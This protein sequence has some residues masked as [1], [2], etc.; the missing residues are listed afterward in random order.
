MTSWGRT[1]MDGNP[2]RRAPFPAPMPSHTPQPASDTALRQLAEAVHATGYRFTTVTPATHELVNR[3]PGNEQARD[4]RDVFGWSRPF[5][6]DILPP[7]LF[8]LMR[9]ADIL[10]ED[11]RGWR[12]LVRL[13]SLDD[14]LFLHSAHPTAAAG[15]VF[16]G[17]DTYRFAAA[18]GAALSA[19]R[20]PVLRAVDIGC[21]AGPGGILVARARPEA[22]VMMVDINDAALRLARINA[23]LAG[24]AAVACRSDLLSDVDG[25][26]DLIVSNP[27]YLLDPGRRAYR[28]GGGTLGEG[29]SLAILDAAL[30]CLAP[31]G[32]LVLYTGVAIVD[33][34]DIFRAAASER[35]AATTTAWIYHEI[36]PDVFGEELAGETYAA[37]DRIAAVVL[38]ATKPGS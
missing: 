37:A 14:D 10:V 22:M 12:S 38:V 24:V 17:P 7:G 4:L 36:D 9:R 16:F 6:P 3:R 20:A 1:G 11:P 18:I 35:L 23:A 30:D 32:T 26:F 28:H 33:G 27:P 29:L 13:S 31:G 15:S 5:R 2:A 19:R 34:E 21:G 25:V 8:D